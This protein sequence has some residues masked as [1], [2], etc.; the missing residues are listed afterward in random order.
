VR[1]GHRVVSKLVCLA[2]CWL[3]LVLPALL[4]WGETEV[5]IAIRLYK[6]EH[7][8]EGKVLLEQF[9]AT[10]QH[11]AQAHY[12][13]G[14]I[15]LKLQDYDKAIEHCQAAVDIQADK[16]EY[17]LCLGLS[18]GKKAQHASFLS[19]AFLAPKI[20]KSFEQT[21]MLDPHQI[22]GRVGLANFYLQAPAVMGGDIDKA[23][24]QAMILL[25]LHA[26]K[27]RRLLDKISQRK[28][29][30]AA[31]AAAQEQEELSD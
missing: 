6:A 31:E 13:L 20:K 25:K 16:A 19:K 28:A 23:R 24:E 27:G 26:E 5:A 18:Y 2:V 11:D 21:V 12:Y 3:V 17:H 29:G 14:R 8:R 9:L 22:Q 7:Y 30:A 15:Y 4:A 10:H 1:D